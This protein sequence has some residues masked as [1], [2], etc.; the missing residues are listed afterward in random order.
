M[1]EEKPREEFK[2]WAFIC[3]SHTD[4][5]WA[6]WLHKRLETYS[7]PKHLVGK[8][9]REG[10]LPKRIFPVFRDREELPGSAKLGEEIEAALRKS[11]YLI[12][13]C[14]PRAVA[15]KW[16]DQE[17]RIFKAL[18]REDRVLCL[19]VEGEPHATTRPE[20]RGP[21]CLP[22]SVRF[23][24]DSERNI[25]QVPTEPIAADI[26]KGKDGK[27]NAV[28]KLLSG[29]LGVEYDALKQR[30][31]E[32]RQKQQHLILAGAVT[33]LIVFSLL[34][35]EFYD[36]KIEAFKAKRI[37][38]EQQSVAVKASEQA[39]LSEVKAL[40]ARE[41]A[42]LSEN[43]ARKSLELAQ[44]EERKARESAKAAENSA[45]AERLANQAKSEALSEAEDARK[46]AEQREQRM[47]RTLAISDFTTAARLVEEGNEPKA[48]AYLSRAI[49]YDPENAAVVS[50]VISL[51]SHK[52]WGLPVI[53]S[54]RHDAEVR[55]V[56]FSQD[57]KFIITLS[58]K[59]V[60]VWDKASAK[61]V[62]AP[63]EHAQQVNAMELSPDGKLLIT[64]SRDR[65]AQLWDL[66][67]GSKVGTPLSHDDWILHANFSPNGKQVATGSQDKTARV[68]DIASSKVI[69][70]LHHSGPVRGV[71]FTP[72]T[73]SLV[74]IASNSARRWD[75]AT[76]HAIGLPMTHEGGVHALSISPNGTWIATGSGDRTARVWSAITGEPITAPLQHH[77]WVVG[78][79]FTPDERQL[80]TAS[81]DRTARLW[82]IPSGNL[83]IPVMQH[84]NEVVAARFSPNARWIVTAGMDGNARIWNA[85]TGQQVVEALNHSFALHDAQFSP[86]GKYVATSSVDRTV[87]LWEITSGK[88]AV[89]ALRHEQQVN[90]ACFSP[91]GSLLATVSNDRSARIWDV[92][93]SQPITEPLRHKGAVVSAAFSPDGQFLA[94]GSED[95][96]AQ[97]WEV[98]TGNQTFSDALPHGSWVNSVS[99]SPD[100]K[101]LVTA[102]ED[103]RARVWDI[104]TGSL[105]YEPLRH[106]G[107]VKS[108]TFSPDGKWIITASYDKNVRVW[109]ASTREAVSPTMEHNG[110]VRAAVLSPDGKWVITGS[111]DKTARIWDP[112]TGKLL[113]DPL[114]HDGPVSLVEFTPAKVWAEKKWV[115]TVCGKVARIWDAATGKAITEPL[116]HD[117]PIRTASFGPHGNLLVTASGK[118][119]YIWET[120]SGRLV[121]EPL[122]HEKVVRSVLFSPDGNFI[123]TT[124]TDQAA[125]IWLATLRGTAP[126]WFSELADAVGGYKLDDHG[127][128]EIFSGSWKNF[129]TIRKE[130]SQA[131]ADDAFAIWTRWFLTDRTSR[132]ISAFSTTMLDNYVH[133][134]I[135]RGEIEAVNEALD[136]QPNNSMALLKAAK[137]SKD[138]F[139]RD[140]LSRLAE[141]YEPLN[142]DVLWLR[143]QILQ[144]LNFPIQALAVMERAIELDPGNIR[145]FGPNGVEFSS[146][147]PA[148]TGASGWL[149]LGWRDF[150]DSK[151]SYSKILDTPHP[152]LTALEMAM[153]TERGRGELRGPRFVCKRNA[154]FVVEG[155]VRSTTRTDLNVVLN[156]FVEPYQKY[157]EQV[158]RTT[159][160]WK[161]FKIQFSSSHDV[162]AELRL[163]PS[164]SGAVQLAGVIVRQE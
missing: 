112:V 92:I 128:A 133:G 26:R 91:D 93:S 140:F 42:L 41:A 139:Q 108:A 68:W 9:T 146:S 119:V 37:A 31:E 29:I 13:I 47:R 161:P 55:N 162:A 135:A 157:K 142:P 39:R 51:L 86:D 94:T 54:L 89:E 11:R 132:T 103:R 56:L 88:P 121:T 114:P 130:I 43:N 2:Y 118:N 35:A 6:D 22:E 66:Q 64:A 126:A 32:R 99:F 123:V 149:P 136:F 120:S 101:W 33:L 49:R 141:Q 110:E 61:L 36:Q 98:K 153:G 15:S 144:Q 105:V 58:G 53:E 28:L 82:N 150:S 138:P 21:E 24:V 164:T 145:T 96:T 18:G 85:T 34:V 102:S 155:W 122:V 8:R 156:Q 137:L 81:S 148:Q 57:G 23:W 60:R 90:S 109:N 134:S 107:I 113:I 19:V 4:E 30:D 38:E 5:K 106:E 16:V 111:E 72:D 14:S 63:L 45:A 71:Q 143:A 116:K 65:T 40:E 125:R 97:I 67:T 124:S 100:G 147:H 74:T 104:A 151:I 78:L 46:L 69:Y 62:Y 76:G 59:A 3:Y 44:D 115:L 77:N 87:K 95:G 158:V 84:D 20:I 160:Q 73:R 127:A 163:L 48:L 75:L 25:T 10:I 117:E 70:T 83:A 17:I 154:K 27:K 52:T 159:A 152:G 131:P 12:V 50:R 80:L 129:V 7:I 79:Q 1:S